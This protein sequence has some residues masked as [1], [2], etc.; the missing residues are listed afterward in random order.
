[1]ARITTNPDGHLYEEIADTIV[2]VCGATPS[3]TPRTRRSVLASLRRGDISLA[4]EE[5]QLI[6]WLL[7]TPYTSDAQELGM[8]YVYP[9]FRGMGILS[10]LIEPLIDKRPVT[11]AATYELRLAEMLQTQWSF[12]QSSLREFSRKTRGAFVLE[13]LRTPA[14]LYA[15]VR[16]V[17]TSKPTYLIRESR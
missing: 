8:A 13:R 10:R 1:M 2:S 7:A 14:M 9:E 5:D 4:Y 12:R 17:S 15:V 11:I 6:G 3:L 16:H